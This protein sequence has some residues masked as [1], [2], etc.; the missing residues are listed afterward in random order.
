MAKKQAA[1]VEQPQED[2]RKRSAI[3]EMAQQE[4]AR[5]CYAEYVWYAHSA[6]V[7]R[8]DGSTKRVSRWF[9]SKHNDFICEQVQNFIESQTGNPYDILI[10]SEPPQHSKSMTITETLP[11]WVYGKHPTWRVIEISYNEDFAQLFGRRN[12]A[13]TQE[14]GKTLFGVTLAKKP[15]SDVEFELSN[16][17]G[18]MI[19]RGVMSGV[20]GRPCELMIIDDPFK[21]RQEAESETYRRRVWDEWQNS[22]KT[23]LAPGA[24]VIIVQ[25]RWHEADLA[26]MVIQY[27]PN[28]KVINLPCE[29]EENDPIGRAVGEPLFPEIGKDAAWL[30]QFKQSY[31][32]SPSS[33]GGG[34][35]AWNAL[36]QGRPAPMEGAMLKR[37]WWKYYTQ[38]PDKFDRVIQSWD[39]TFKDSDG[40]DF[41]SGQVW[42]C[43]GA[44]I[45]MLPDREY[46]RMDFVQTCEAFERLTARNQQAVEKLVED[47]AN[48][49]AVI[50][51]LRKK[52]QGII[53]IT[54][55]ES[56]IAR[57]S[58]VS[59]LIEAGN[60]W[61]PSPMLCPWITDFV[62][63]CSVFPNGAH[64]DMVDSATQALTRL[65]HA[66]APAVQSEQKFVWAHEK[67]KNDDWCGGDFDLSYINFGGW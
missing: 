25:T 50:A 31:I 9:R 21:N 1:P 53:P 7:K 27:E 39:M 5:Q 8:P 65:M 59:P 58:A 13:K 16:R 57:A 38:V 47:K 51:M 63:E 33:D 30:A 35:R 44:D 15:N 41:V 24:K 32:N 37:N 29:A 2:A 26:G 6:R 60:V 55:K 3:A 61:L 22:F 28:V 20:T 36:F 43:R 49:P 52:I 19:S 56:K 23:R 17:I 66:R 42:G 45:Y 18:G 64:D 67:P 46:G 4:L 40:S 48:G 14:Y 34:I 11:S 54:P 62:D 12:R 10:I